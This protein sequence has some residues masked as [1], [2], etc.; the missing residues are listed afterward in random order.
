ML[1]CCSLSTTER[2]LITGVAEAFDQ[3]SPL[4]IANE[5]YDLTQKELVDA[6]HVGDR[7]YEY[8]YTASEIK[9]ITSSV[10]ISPGQ[11]I[12]VPGG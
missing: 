12:G 2:F 6:G 5:L 4:G 10:R 8:I 7:I 11:A 9:L 3:L 1:P